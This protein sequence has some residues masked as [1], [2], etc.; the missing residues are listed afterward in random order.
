MTTIIKNSATHSSV[1]LVNTAPTRIE[2]EGNRSSIALLIINVAT[3]IL[4]ILTALSILVFLGSSITSIVLAITKSKNLKTFLI[5]TGVCLLIIV[6]SILI[7]TILR[8][9]SANL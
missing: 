3:F 9:I 7:F 1:G 2:V 5:I 8:V 4:Y 6:L